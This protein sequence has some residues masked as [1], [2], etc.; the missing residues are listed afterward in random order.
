VP[1]DTLA[2]SV[3]TRAGA[4]GAEVAGV[5]EGLVGGSVWDRENDEDDAEDLTDE[6]DRE[7]PR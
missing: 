5:R 6:A 3:G 7:G 2:G 4:A 1:A